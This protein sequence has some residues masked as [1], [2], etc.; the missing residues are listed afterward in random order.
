MSQHLSLRIARHLLLL[1]ALGV[2]AV[3]VEDL[4]LPAGQRQR[5]T[6]FALG[7][8]RRRPIG[9]AGVSPKKRNQGPVQHRELFAATAEMGMDGGP[10][11]IGTAQIDDGQRLQEGQHSSRT[12]IEAQATQ[13]LTEMQPVPG[14]DDAGLRH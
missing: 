5:L 12:R 1:R 3:I 13:D 10:H 6:S 9:G 8:V 7:G 14:K 2:L 4:E 11:V